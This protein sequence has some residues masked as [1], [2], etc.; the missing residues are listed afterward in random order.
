MT[1]NQNGFP[2][3]VFTLA[4]LVLA[5]ALGLHGCAGPQVKMLTDNRYEPRPESFEVDLYQGGVQTPH[6]EIAKLDSLAVDELTTAAREVLVEDLRKRA[7]KL[8]ADAVTD[9]VLLTGS[10]RGWVR[11][12]QTPFRS[13]KQG[14]G[15]RYFLRGTAVRFKPVLM[16]AGEGAV[17][18]DPF[19]FG[20]GE[21]PEGWRKAPSDDLE[22]Y[23]TTDREGRKGWGSR[24]KSTK[25]RQPLAPTIELGG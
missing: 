4:A 3:R 1:T 17:L 21:R 13:Y 11:D 19:V 10:I 5:G 18:G 7:R 23:E 6:Q 22:I 12:P 8:G 9:V 25:P 2:G 24:R 15:D 14:W 16:E 20:E